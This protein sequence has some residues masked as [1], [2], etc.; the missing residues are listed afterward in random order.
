MCP[1]YKLEHLLGICPG[2]KLL[3]LPVVLYPIFLGTADW[4][5]EWLYQLAIPPTMEECSSFS[6]SSQ[7]SAV[8]WIFDLSHFN[9]C[10]VE[11]QGYFDL[12][13]ISLMIKHVEHFFFRCFSAIQYSSA[14]NSHLRSVPHFYRVIWFSGVHLLEFFIYI[15]DINALHDLG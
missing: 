6:T 9:W 15:L 7:A 10:E 1:Y 13:C 11:S 3:D 8:T 2:E 5:P 12:I 14:E 4:F